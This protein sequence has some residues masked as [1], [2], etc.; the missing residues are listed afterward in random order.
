MW[1]QFIIIKITAF[2]IAFA[3]VL[4]KSFLSLCFLICK[5]WKLLYFFQLGLITMAY[6]RSLVFG[7]PLINIG[8][9]LYFEAA[10]RHGRKSNSKE[11]N[12]NTKAENKF[13]NRYSFIGRNRPFL[14]AGECGGKGFENTGQSS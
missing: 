12:L 7:L 11:G 8:S 2:T 10:Y 9:L 13:K 6:V 4:S 14:E 1:G 3:M 5:K